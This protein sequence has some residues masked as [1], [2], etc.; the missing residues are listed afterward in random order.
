MRSAV[1]RVAGW[2]ILSTIGA[3]ACSSNPD[4]ACHAGA[5]CASGI[6]L[7]DGTCAPPSGSDGGGTADA[8]SGSDAPDDVLQT[9]D[10]P[11][12]GCVPNNDGTILASE[13]PLKAGLHA[14][15]RVATNVT[16]DTAGQTQGNGSRTWDLSGALGGDQDMAIDTVAI[17]GAWYAASFGSA[18]YA[19]RMSVQTNLLGVFRTSG[20]GLLLDGIVSPTSSAP[21]TNVTYK[22]EVEALAFPLTMNA[23]WNTTSTVQG[24]AAGVPVLYT[25]AYASQVDAHGT[26]KTPFGTF[27]VLRARTTLTRTVGI[28]VT[29]IR[30]FSFV[31]EC[32]G[33]IAT[34]TSQ[35]D[36][37]NVEFTS[38]A[39][40]QRLAP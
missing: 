38:A 39:E 34:V 36:E 28:T 25:E 3:S 23:T 30:S 37:P 10:T 2:A 7:S 6:C 21:Q 11:V 4:A 5:D 8:L 26:M 14:N 9:S 18:S 22:P 35:V 33:T 24:T 15:F 13:V 40:V 12:T 27:D 1:F 16:V 19:A 17:S 20:S 29:V 32:F 31:T